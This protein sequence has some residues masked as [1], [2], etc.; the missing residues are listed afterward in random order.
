MS[1]KPT[2]KKISNFVE[3]YIKL[4]QSDPT[5]SSEYIYKVPASELNNLGD[6]LRDD[7]CRVYLCFYPLSDQEY[8]KKND[9]FMFAEYHYPKR[10]TLKDGK[11]KLE[12][13]VVIPAKDR[14]VDKAKI[15]EII[16]HELDHAYETWHKLQP[17]TNTN[18]NTDNKLSYFAK[19]FKTAKKRKTIK[20]QLKDYDN[21][22]PQQDGTFH[23]DFRWVAYF[24]VDL[25]ISANL[26][27]INAFLQEN[28]NDKTKLELSRGYQTF[29]I[30]KEKF[31]KIKTNATNSDW[32]WAQRNV[33]YIGTNK[34]EN[35]SDFK[36]RFIEYYEHKFNEFENNLKKITTKTNDKHNTLKSASDKLTQKIILKT[37]QSNKKDSL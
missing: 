29:Q 33:S 36:K 25:E 6:F 20:K 5:I 15:V 1:I 28:N 19:L 2:P 23:D 4:F 11:L 35:V 16:A 8:D 24:C 9:E 26:A 32:A 12:L 3:K 17:T 18:T 34:Q 7:D 27:G 31:E 37:K 14:Y 30:I 21:I 22:L 10:M 13:N